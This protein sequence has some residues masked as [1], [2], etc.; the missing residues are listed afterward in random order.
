DYDEL[1][2]IYSHL[3]STTTVGSAGLASPSAAAAPDSGE[4]AAAWG[5]A[6]A[7][8]GDGRGRVFHLDIGAGRALIT[9]VLWAPSAS[10]P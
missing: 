7:F 4:S 5:R 2:T 6:V 8:T 1:V 10:V 9:F 3:D